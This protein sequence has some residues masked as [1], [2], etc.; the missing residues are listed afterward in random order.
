[1]LI[2]ATNNTLPISSPSFV[3]PHEAIVS[4]SLFFA[5][6]CCS[7]FAAFGAVLAK[8]WLSEYERVGENRSLY[9]RGRQR[10]SKYVAMKEY[11]CEV[12][13][14]ALGSVLQFSLFLFLVALA[15]WLWSINT[16]VAS[17]V[18]AGVI[19][20]L[21]FYILTT[22]VSVSNEFSPFTTR[23]SATLRRLL[24][25]PLDRSLA[26]S[27]ACV[28]WMNDHA[29]SFNSARATAIAWASLRDDPHK[30]SHSSAASKFVRAVV[31][32]DAIAV[33]YANSTLETTLRA[34][35]AVEPWK[36]AAGEMICLD[37]MGWSVVNSLLNTLALSAAKRDFPLCGSIIDTLPDVRHT[38]IR[39][40]FTPGPVPF[41]EVITSPQTS[42]Y[43]RERA[44][45]WVL[46][47]QEWQ[48]NFP[49]YFPEPEAAS[50]QWR[51]ARHLKQSKPVASP[52][53]FTPSEELLLILS[54]QTGLQSPRNWDSWTSIF[55]RN[56][57]I[58]ETSASSE[59]LL[60][61]PSQASHYLLHFALQKHHAD[62]SDPFEV[63]WSLVRLYLKRAT[64][65]FS[66]SV[67]WIG[68]LLWVHESLKRREVEPS[69]ELPPTDRGLLY[70]A[71]RYLSTQAWHYRLLDAI[72]PKAIWRYKA[73]AEALKSYADLCSS[74]PE[75]PLTDSTYARDSDG[76][77][78]S[79]VAAD[80]H[81]APEPI[82]L[83]V[84]AIKNASIKLGG[85]GMCAETGRTEI[86]A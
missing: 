42:R 49:D 78:T 29:V 27:G 21:I 70:W 64:E 19:A 62:P 61:S 34:L 63:P 51:V 17:V 83:L 65:E 37:E 86:H 68:P 20:T 74:D 32:S 54:N 43:V 76:Q 4:N 2:Q 28:S 44:C 6:L 71:T 7:L 82:R 45:S 66:P 12:V 84:E 5:G 60:V 81:S 18:I 53:H 38:L 9:I 67:P 46:I 26:A 72:S 57:Y 48:R 30:P 85:E 79:I 13:I 80:W 36:S 77:L 58:G 50:W 47:H 73:L 3:A 52:N 56:Y 23:V 25:A 22:V 1:M 59:T 35:D 33:G 41:V 14:Q 39:F 11:H 8:E 40:Y 31:S 24:S 15:Y 69:L 10:H 55:P 16:T 75:S